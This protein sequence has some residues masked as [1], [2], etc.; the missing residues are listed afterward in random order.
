MQNSVTAKDQKENGTY[1]SPVLKVTGLHKAFGGL[2]AINGVSFEV[3][4]G[5]IFAI[6]G[7]NGAGKTTLFN[8]IN[9]FLPHDKGEIN[10]SG[11]NLGRLPPQRIAALGIARTFQ[12]L[13]LFTN[14]N[15]IE[16]VMMGR[17][18]QSKAGMFG[19]AFRLPHARKEERTIS[20]SAMNKLEM[21]GLK[22]EAFN[23][24]LNLPLGKQKML[25]LARALATEPKLL[26]IDEP[27]GGL[28]TREIE[29]LARLI[30][31]IRQ[32][33]VTCLLVEHRMEL[34]MEIAERLLVLNFGAKIAE[35]AP[36]E[37][38]NDEQVI[39][40]YLGEDF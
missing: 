16:N 14:M 17:H 18:L 34:V 23:E 25:E 36:D 31:R 27:A 26:L 10:F 38:Q 33:G 35:G 24:P 8:V 11:R 30:R 5:E 39:T 2:L 1:R 19:T 28:S 32:S 29:E 37:V 12:N 21:V 3:K 4:H 13:Q 15:V 7:P 6:I 20:E 40:A 22:E 9:G